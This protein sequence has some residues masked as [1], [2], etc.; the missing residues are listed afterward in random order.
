MA[1]WGPIG[2]FVGF[3]PTA[4]M[5]DTLHLRPT[6]IAGMGLV[7]AGT[8]VR[9]IATDNVPLYNGTNVTTTTIV[10][11]VGQALNGL[12]GPFAMSAGTVMSAAWFAPEERT[13]STAVFCTANQVGVTLSYIAGPLMVPVDGTSSDIRMYM[14]VSAGVAG[15]V[16]LMTVAYLPSKPPHGELLTKPLEIHCAHSIDCGFVGRD[17]PGH[18]PSASA[19]VERTPIGQGALLLLRN[20]E[21]WL[22]TVAYAFC[23]GFFAGWAPLYAII[24]QWLGPDVA[25]N[26][27]VGKHVYTRRL[28][29]LSSL[30]EQLSVVIGNCLLGRLLEQYFRKSSRNA[31][32]MAVG[33]RLGQKEGMLPCTSCA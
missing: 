21:F 18:E 10:Q 4:W 27:Q 3:A 11:H 8:L 24:I 22:V 19:E 20:R 12:A 32:C 7:F 15:A 2:Y 17:V 5:L 30:I 1:L 13:V 25:P 16:F 28:T 26:P 6:A 29:A 23:T 9:L 33:Q 14:W 31:I